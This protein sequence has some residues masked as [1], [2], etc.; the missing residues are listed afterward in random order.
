MKSRCSCKVSIKQVNLKCSSITEE[1][2]KEIF[3]YFWSLSWDEKKI[4]VD[5]T[6]SLVSIN[7]PRNRKESDISRR[8]QSVLYH[9]RVNDTNIRVCRVMFLNTLAIGRMTVLDWKQQKRPSTNKT[10][11]EEN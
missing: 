9:L 3:Q 8:S 4:F 6:V 2:R 5:S 7:R 10:K 1:D 11:T